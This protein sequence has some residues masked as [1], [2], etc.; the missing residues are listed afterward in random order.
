[1]R[2]PA[3]SRIGITRICEIIGSGHELS[4]Q[5]RRQN[6]SDTRLHLVS[7]KVA[8][9]NAN[10]RYPKLYGSTYFLQIQINSIYRQSG[11]PVFYILGTRTPVTIIK[12]HLIVN[13][14]DKHLRLDGK[15]NGRGRAEDKPRENEVYAR[16][17]RTRGKE[18]N[19]LT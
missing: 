4:N 14:A 7:V 8:G 6:G 18:R 16:T 2:S 10:R 17:S 5:Y 1:M 11:H 9:S 13:T 19:T 3:T 12:F 15:A